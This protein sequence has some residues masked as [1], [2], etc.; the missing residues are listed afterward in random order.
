MRILS[1][2]LMIG[3]LVC[4]ATGQ[5]RAGSEAEKTAVSA[6]QAWLALI[7]SGNYSLSWKEASA[8][9]RGAVTEKSWGASMEGF[10]QPLG[11]LISR[12]I[13]KTQEAA[14]LPGA[15]DGRYVV[16]SFETSFQKK[17]FATETVTLMLDNDQ[18]WRA[19][20]YFIK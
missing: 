1:L 17:R 20:G 4:F 7:D 12:K 13:V 14:S 6:A 10:R 5:S 19:A 16:M 11:K 9:F 2:V 15:P 3:L 18:K 8:Y